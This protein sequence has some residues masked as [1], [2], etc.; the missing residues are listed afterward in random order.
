MQNLSVDLLSRACF[1]F[2]AV[3][4]SCKSFNVDYVLNQLQSIDCSKSI[5]V[6]GMHPKLL[7]IS[8]KII[9][10]LERI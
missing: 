4:V 6:D 8:A 5:G 3:K 1:L 7:K 9:I 2:I 10:L